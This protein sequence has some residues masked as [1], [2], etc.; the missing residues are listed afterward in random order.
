[1]VD[2]FALKLQRFR[3]EH[4]IT[5]RD[6]SRLAGVSLSAIQKWEQGRR[7]PHPLMQASID[8]MIRRYDA[9]HANG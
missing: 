6:L 9:T 7:H 5:Q 2:E 3:E 4:H 8:N 1:M